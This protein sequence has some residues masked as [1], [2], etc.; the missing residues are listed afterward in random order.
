M[1]KVLKKHPRQRGLKLRGRG[2]YD[3][4]KPPIITM[5]ERGTRK[6]ILIVEKNLSKD[7]IHS[8]IETHCEGLIKAFTDDY[9]IYIGLG[10]HPQVIEHHV[11]NHSEKEYADGETHVN[12]CEN[13]HSL[14]K[15]YLRIFRGVSK[16]KL[17]TYIKFFQ[18]TFNNGINWLEK[19]LELILQQCT[20]TGR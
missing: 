5:I 12:N 11:I 8:K 4:D 14:L 1:I 6:T 20:L 16:K 10:E 18:F 3:K 15:P 9:T 7:L 17:N 13:R 2:T 19:A